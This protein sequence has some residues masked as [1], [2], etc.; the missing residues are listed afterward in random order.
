M[1]LK[2]SGPLRLVIDAMVPLSRWASLGQYLGSGSRLLLQGRSW[3]WV[4]SS[5]CFSSF[6]VITGFWDQSKLLEIA[7]ELFL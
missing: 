5:T 7:F 4:Y 1:I 3:S 2:L 6:I